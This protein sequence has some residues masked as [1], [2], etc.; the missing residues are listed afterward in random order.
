MIS[1]NIATHKARK[2]FLKPCIESVLAG[3][4]VPDVINVYFN[5]YKAPAWFKSMFVEGCKIVAFE[6]PKGD[7]GASAKFYGSER[8]NEG[9]YMT[10]DDD[11][12]VSREYIGY[13]ADS[14][15]RFPQSIVGLHGT[16]YRFFPVQSYYLD[17][18]RSVNYCYHGKSETSIVDMLGT[19]CI[20]FRAAMETKP[21][22]SDFP[23]ANMTDPYLFKWAKKTETPL[24]CLVRA[25]GLVKEQPDSQ[26]SAIW[27]G[28]LDGDDEQTKV[29]NSACKEGYLRM[30]SIK[31]S[32]IQ[33]P[34]KTLGEAS[35]EWGHIKEIMSQW[36]NEHGDLLVEFG[37][38]KSTAIFS[39]IGNVF[40]F[41][42]DSN[43][44][45]HEN[46][47]HSPLKGGWYDLKPEDKAIIKEASVIVIDGPV[48]MTGERYN[49]DLSVLPKK[50]CIVF[51]DDCHRPKDKEMAEQIAKH[52]KR[53]AKF[54]QGLEKTIA[55]I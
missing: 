50:D 49:F 45:N 9:V 2:K 32:S 35:I 42:H 55:K 48:G 31:P 37:S 41:D 38:G 46:I 47:I 3:N 20:A 1:L 5:D 6:S 28:L 25:A 12:I 18:G 52:L 15:Y 13:M 36:K 19:G 4:T 23:E 30:K 40:S 51:I 24:V 53:K 10:I 21:V 22:L 26:D 14:A 43:Y 16:D 27:K 11:L 39:M 33:I 29:I 17:A 8:Q 44:V 34:T 54:I 7:L